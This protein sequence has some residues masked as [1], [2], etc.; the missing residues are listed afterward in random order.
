MKLT[1]HFT[2]SA[3]LNWRWYFSFFD[4]VSKE[5]LADAKKSVYFLVLQKCFFYKNIL[6]VREES[7]SQVIATCEI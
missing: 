7:S 5:K 1:V 4:L 3:K 6:D 2:K